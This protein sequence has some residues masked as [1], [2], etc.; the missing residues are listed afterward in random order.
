[1]V[2]QA[3]T[4]AAQH[5]RFA[6][7]GYNLPYA[8]LEAARHLLYLYFYLSSRS[9]GSTSRRGTSY[10]GSTQRIHLGG[11]TGLWCVAVAETLA[12]LTLYLYITLTNRAKS[13]LVDLESWEGHT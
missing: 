2:K 3:N 5:R 6:A 7:T 11:C 9:S 8:P 1:M 10:G 12:K 13:V 4:T